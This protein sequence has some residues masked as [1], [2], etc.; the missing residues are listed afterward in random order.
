MPAVHGVSL[1]NGLLSFNF[2][3]N[4]FIYLL[5]FAV[6]G[7][8]CRTGLSLVVMHRLLIVVASLAVEYML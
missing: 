5:I 4:T 7:L 1:L 8:C 6:L 2:F 3:F